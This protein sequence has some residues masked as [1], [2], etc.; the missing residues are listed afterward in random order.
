MK[1][2]ISFGLRL[3]PLVA[4]ASL[5]FVLACGS[6]EEPEAPKQ[7]APAA[8]AA[9]APA[10]MAGE[11]MA[12]AKPDQPAPAAM[13]Q[14]PVAMTMPETMKPTPEEPSRPL[15]EYE[16]MMEDPGTPKEG[17]TVLWA[18]GNTPSVDWSCHTTFRGGVSQHV[19]EGFF[20]ANHDRTETLPLSI[21]SWSLSDDGKEYTLTLR[22]GQTFHDGTPVESADAIASTERWFGSTHAI[23]KQIHGLI[24]PVEHAV[25]DSKTYTMSMSRAFAL[26]P[27]Y[28]AFNGAWIQPEAISNTDPHDCIDTQT[29][30]IGHGPYSYIEWIPGDRVSMERFE[31]Y[32]PRRRA[33]ERHRWRERYPTLTTSRLIVVPDHC[34]PVSLALRTGQIHIV[35]TRRGRVTSRRPLQADPE[36]DRG[37]DRP[38][39]SA[40]LGLQQGY[41]A[42]FNNK[43]AR[44]AV[45]M[46]ADMEAV[47]DRL[48]RSDQETGDWSLGRRHLHV[49]RTVGH[50][51]SDR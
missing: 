12:A 36:V 37:R 13:A 41:Q 24:K 5:A 47:D 43:K 7:P 29:Q 14:D 19:Y 25:V 50:A 9:E 48:L 4:I 8:P 17:G 15:I 30:V 16:G 32:V 27:V 3:L 42:P 31:D 44:Q 21:G 33:C 11:G 38:R 2:T 35:P 51:G 40:L 6:P 39:Q 46:A 26:W 1:G 45:L 49:R 23:S 20:V 10:A 18:V 34:D 22:D 28:Q